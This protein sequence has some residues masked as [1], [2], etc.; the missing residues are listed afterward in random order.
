MR[1]LLGRTARVTSH[2]NPCTEGIQGRILNDTRNT[3]TIGTA[4]VP[5]KN[6]ALD[7]DGITVEG[8]SLIGRTEERL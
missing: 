6:A 2:P 7:V 1:N 8:S 3:L 5:K 4:V